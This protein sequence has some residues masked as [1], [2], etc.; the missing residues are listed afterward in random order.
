MSRSAS[1]PSLIVHRTRG[2]TTGDQTF[3]VASPY[4][5]G[6][7]IVRRSDSPKVCGLGLGLEMYLIGLSD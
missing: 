4:V 6:C 2:S 3:P 5:G 7:S 1:S